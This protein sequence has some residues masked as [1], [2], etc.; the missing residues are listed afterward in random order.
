MNFIQ[1]AIN[2][3]RGKEFNQSDYSLA[4]GFTTTGY[5]RD[6]SVK[7]VDAFES[8][9]YIAVNKNAIG[10][11]S[12]QLRLYVSNSTPQKEIP[13]TTRKL[14]RKESSV[15][16]SVNAN[17]DVE[18]ILDHPF[19]N[20]F[21]RPNPT[22]SGFEMM[23]LLSTY[24]D[25]TGNAYWYLE[26]DAMGIV[27]SIWP[28]PSQNVGVKKETDGALTYTYRA[29]V[30]QVVFNQSEIIHFKTPSPMSLLAGYAPLQ[31]ISAAYNIIKTIDRIDMAM[32]KNMGKPELIVTPPT[33]LS[34]TGDEIES[35]KAMFQARHAGVDNAGKAFFASIPLTVQAINHNNELGNIE[36]RKLRAEEVVAAFGMDMSVL[37]PGSNRAEAETAKIFW[38]ESAIIPRLKRIENK[39]NIIIE[40]VY[41][42]QFFV[43]FD[44]PKPMDDEFLLRQSEIDIRSGI[45]TRNEVRAERG[46]APL[47]P[48]DG[49]VVPSFPSQSPSWGAPGAPAK[50]I[51]Q[52]I[53]ERL[54]GKNR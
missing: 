35:L 9:V 39:L 31:A 33:G 42:K 49:D 40:Q 13:F 24:L 17:S 8:W 20:V 54:H 53:I 34:L 3:I 10:V 29:G 5:S 44:N 19:I 50:E 27:R 37:R 32:F 36:S 15:I 38:Y 48:N 11:A 1:R 4:R 52:G 26:K 41:G 6:D 25:L 28:L 21:N 46:L 22:M 47:P 45:R 12:T 43:A 16:K 51:A 30:K 23:E 7:G 2:R 14:S 18:E